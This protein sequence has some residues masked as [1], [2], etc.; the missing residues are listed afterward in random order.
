MPKRIALAT[1]VVQPHRDGTSTTYDKAVIL[2]LNFNV[3]QKAAVVEFALCESSTG[4]IGERFTKTYA[5]GELPGAY[6]NA[7]KQML[8]WHLNQVKG[9]EVPDGALE[10]A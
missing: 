2:G 8:D 1:P 4:K 9:G 10:E 5:A 7:V 3:T 6:V